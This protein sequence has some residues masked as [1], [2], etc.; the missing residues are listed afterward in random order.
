VA[1]SEKFLASIALV[2]GDIA[3]NLKCA[4]DYAWIKTIEVAAPSAISDFAKF[5]ARNGLLVHGLLYYVIGPKELRVDAVGSRK[6]R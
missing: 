6:P 4:L 3:H 5:P 2:L 1:D